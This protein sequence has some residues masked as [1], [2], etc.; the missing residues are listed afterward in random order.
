M[1][2]FS[3]DDL[4]GYLFYNVKKRGRKCLTYDVVTTKAK[5]INDTIS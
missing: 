4:F 3:G 1:D 5:I 2:V